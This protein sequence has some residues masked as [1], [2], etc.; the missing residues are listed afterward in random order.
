MS[1]DTNHYLFDFDGVLVDS[2]EI[3]VGIHSGNLRAAGIP[4]PEDFVQTITPLGN[5]HGAKYVLSLGVQLPLEDYLEQTAQQLMIA[6]STQVPLKP[7]VA[8][9]LKQLKQQGISL[10]V[11]TANSRAFVDNCL[12]RW[13][14]YDLFDNVWIMDDFG[15]TKDNPEIYRQAAARLGAEVSACTM[16]DDNLKAISAAG[17]AGLHTVG[18]YDY[19]S[20]NTEPAMRQTAQ[21][22]ITDFS[23]I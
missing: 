1:T 10:H 9:T 18:V 3:W 4:V 8:E 14:V 16:F 17:D 11:L 12:K 5:Y 21:R 7:H 6:Y 19:V 22:Y 13:Q 20:R 2:M 15:L 23:Q